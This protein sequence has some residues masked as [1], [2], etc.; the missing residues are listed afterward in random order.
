VVLLLYLSAGRFS[1]SQ[2]AQETR[3]QV[4]NRNLN[5]YG[6]S[7]RVRDRKAQKRLGIVRRSIWLPNW[8]G[9]T[10]AIWK[11]MLQSWRSVDLGYLYNLLIFFGVGLGL[12]FIPSLGG[13]ILLIL[14]L[15]LQAT[16]FLTRRL[17]EDLAHWVLLRQLPLKPLA[18]ILSDLAFSSGLLLL[19]TLAG[20]AGG[21]LLGNQPL[22]S[23]GLSLPGMI[24]SIAGVSAFMIF[25]HSRI[26]LLLFGQAP[27]VNEFGVLIAVVCASIPVAIYSL[28]P[29][30][31]GAIGG[32]LASLLIGLI[33]LNAAGNAF[34]HID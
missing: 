10:A 2:A 17:R 32:M 29:G 28:L 26:D 23:A 7:S 31:A 18:L 5:R 30:F 21:S 34:R 24:A 9:A 20:M 13:R 33:A 22:L 11:D 19:V 14:T 6:F 16:Q 12:V 3:T 4:T 25:R 8:R 15:A 1:A 27:S